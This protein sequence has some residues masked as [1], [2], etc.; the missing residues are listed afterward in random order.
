MKKQNISSYQLSIEQVDAILELRL[1]KLTAFEL[2]KQK[3]KLVNC[4][5]QLLPLK[6]LLTLKKPY[7]I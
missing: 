1:Q 5:S 4:Q 2:E 7:T 3:L 6:K